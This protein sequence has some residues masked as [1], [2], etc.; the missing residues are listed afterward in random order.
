MGIG[1][2][3]E[4]WTTL[5]QPMRTDEANYSKQ[6]EAMFERIYTKS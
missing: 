5:P 6:V 2:C 4:E 1:F 3:I